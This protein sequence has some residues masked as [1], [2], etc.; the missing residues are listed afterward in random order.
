MI[1]NSNRTLNLSDSAC[2]PSPCKDERQDEPAHVLLT[3]QK[4]TLYFCAPDSPFSTH[5]TQQKNHI[6]NH[7]H[8]SSREHTHRQHAK[9][10]NRAQHKQKNTI[11]NT[12]HSSIINHHIY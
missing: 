5:G 11:I 4:D 8:I 7:T 3:K 1:S 2:T 12:I 6:Q 9:K 10:Q